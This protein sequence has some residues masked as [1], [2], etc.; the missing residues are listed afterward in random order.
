MLPM[1]SRLVPMTGRYALDD[2]LLL[3][4]VDSASTP[5]RIVPGFENIDPA[6]IY[7]RNVEHRTDRKNSDDCGNRRTKRTHRCNVARICGTRFPAPSSSRRRATAA[8]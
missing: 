8:N 6:D 2:G 1:N 3:G 5:Q 7:H 4:A